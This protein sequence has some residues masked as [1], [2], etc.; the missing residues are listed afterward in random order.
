MTEWEGPQWVLA[1]LY[2][3]GMVLRVILMPT[4]ISAVRASGSSLAWRPG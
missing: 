2:A 1:T 3:V 4:R